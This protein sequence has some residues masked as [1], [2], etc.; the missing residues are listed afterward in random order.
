M[1]DQSATQF[2]VSSNDKVAEFADLLFKSGVILQGDISHL[3]EK[4]KSPE[5]VF[6]ALDS[7]KMY[8]NIKLTEIY[9]KFLS[10]PYIIIEEVDPEAQKLIDKALSLR[11]GFVPFSLD[12]KNRVLQ[13]AILEPEKFKNLNKQAIEKLEEKLSL[14]IEL[15]MASRDLANELLNPS[16]KEEEKKPEDKPTDKP[17]NKIEIIDLS[18]IEIPEDILRKM[19]YDLAE[20]FRAIIFKQNKDGTFDIASENPNDPKLAEI[21]DFVQSKGNI[22]LNLFQVSGEQINQ[23]LKKYEDLHNKK[24]EVELSTKEDKTQ[25]EEEPKTEQKEDIEEVKKESPLAGEEEKP[26]EAQSEDSKQEEKKQAEATKQQKELENPDLIAFLGRD[27]VD[28]DD[29]KQYANSDQIPKLVAAILMLATRDRASDVHIEPFEKTVRVRYRIDGELS[30]VSLLPANLISSIVARVKILSKLKLDEQRVPQD[31]RFDVSV[32]KEVVDIRV[33]TLPT[34]FGEKIVMRLL[35]KT[36]NMDKLEDLGIDGLGYDRVIEAIAKPYGVILSTG[37]TGSGKTTTL[38]SILSRLNRPEVNIITLEDPVEYELPGIN[39]VQVKPQIGF[40]FAEGLRSVLRQDPNII[41]VGEI[42]DSETAELVTHAALTGHLVLST[43]HTN[44]A[45]GALPRLYNLGVEPFLL[46]SAINAIMGQRLVRRICQK[47]RVEISVPQSVQFAVKKELEKLN[48]NI[49]MKFFK[50]KGCPDCKDGFSGRIG[51]Y[52]VL[53]MSSAIENLVLAKKSSD[54]IFSQA[55]KEG[56][57]TMR[58][59]GFIKAIKGLTTVDEVL[60]VSGVS[61]GISEGG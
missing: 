23:V 61:K 5:E 55:T 40:S 47:C 15:F 22:K 1:E 48:L 26:E 6:E 51:I 28:T 10:I 24:K 7:S 41:M 54:E 56:M 25:K 4:Y 8:S 11:F 52:E 44:D 39:Q 31:G 36:H 12:L 9:A 42:R 45:S 19:P 20:K 21:I 29:I 34:V 38:Y 27:K 35:S 58:Q 13:V 37:P 32:G 2:K 49:P 18:K 43:L 3:K 57:I 30:D 14:Q 50:G 60:R 17:E 46:T 33:S 59:D 53:T 16:K